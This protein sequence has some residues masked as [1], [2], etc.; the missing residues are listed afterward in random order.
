MFL[1]SFEA[2]LALHP[3][4]FER[5]NS[6]INPYAVGISAAAYALFTVFTVPASAFEHSIDIS[7]VC[8]EIES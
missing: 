5:I 3:E 4:G 2:L 6:I 8:E 1:I 7:D